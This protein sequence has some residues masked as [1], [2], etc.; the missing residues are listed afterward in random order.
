MTEVSVP[1][2]LPEGATPLD[3]D[4]SV[5]LIPIHVT[6]QKELNEWEQ[7]NILAALDWAQSSRQEV[8]TEGFVRDLHRHMFDATWRWAG[9]YRTTEKNIGCDPAQIAVKIVD[10]L[11]DAQCWI[12]QSA[13]E[14]DEAAV[15]FSHRMVAIHPFANGNGRHSRLIA[16][17]LI[18]RLGRTSF[19]WGQSNLS[20]EGEARNAYLR[21]LRAADAR[22]YAPLLQFAR[23]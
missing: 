18:T 8:L 10:L 22:D 13:Y 6:T 2:H 1:E 23:S 15:R 7:T 11:R 5:G 4:E 17:L 16:D 21:A 9:S 12:R 3:H 19:S 20:T 14:P